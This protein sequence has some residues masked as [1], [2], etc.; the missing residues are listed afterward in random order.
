VAGTVNGIRFYKGS[1]N[2]GT[3]IG[4]LWSSSGTL[5][6]TVTFSNET[7][8]GWQQGTFSTPVSIQANTT[9]IASYYCPRGYYSVNTY[10]LS[11]AVD[12]APLHALQDS[13]GSGNGVYVYGQS[14]FPNQS[15]QASKYWVDVLFTPN[16][17]QATSSSTGS[18]TI[19]SSNTVPGTVTDPDSGSIEVGLKFRS[20][21]TGSV[22]GVRFYK[23][24]SNT[25]THVGHLWSRSGS[26][27]AS[28]AFGNETATGWQ[29]ANF[30]NPVAIQAN[31]TYIISYYCPRGHYST[32]VNFFNS[33]VNNGVLHALQ[34]GTDGPNG[35]YVYGSG[36]FPNQ[37][38]NASNYWV[39]VVFSG[40][41]SSG[42]SG[43]GGSGSSGGTPPSPGTYS[44][45]GKVSGTVA[46]LTLSGATGGSTKTDSSGNY[47]FTG[48]ANGSYV[49][50]PSQS[51]YSFSPSTASVSVNGGNV[52]AVNF[53]A[54]TA[55]APV[56]HS[57][58]L[59]WTASTSPN[60]A[61]YKVY[62]GTTSGGPYAA[63][64]GSLVN[65]T[66]YVDDTV[67]SG[68][69]YYYVATAVDSSNSESEY[70]DEAMAAVPTP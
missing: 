29:Q 46:T 38:W 23:G 26:L 33:A 2:T 40:S 66:S 18:A 24:S 68:Q 6:A 47:S 37:S 14:G 10:G 15:W 1:Q 8:S 32:D 48:L 61:G 50:A 62:R 16:A 22:T 58:S 70:S 45:S 25:G 30:S 35:V 27:L 12:N 65:G 60:I 36:G 4:H 13:S 53:T 20:E 17:S 57:V 54:S 28:V 63:V 49:V 56:Q 11:S 31:T 3:H 42:G 21:V 19:W 5:L 64:T 39:D 69:T 44:I 9:Y 55:P 43:S 41:T 67:T 52:T 51:G 34:N 59:N 7:A